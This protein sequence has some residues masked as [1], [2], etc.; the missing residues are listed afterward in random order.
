MFKCFI[1]QAV[2]VPCQSL[3]SHLRLDH[4]FYPSTRFK[5]V[6]AQDRCRRQFSTYSG[7]KKHLISSHENDSCQNGDAASPESF[8]TNFHMLQDTSEF[9]GTSV[10]QN[11][12]SECLDGSGQRNQENTENICAT[13][14]AKL[15][16]SG[17]A[18]SVVSSVVGDLEEL[19][20]G[21]HSQVKQQVLSA[22]PKDNPVRAKLEK[23]LQTFE[24]PF[25]NFSTE[26]KRLKYFNKKWGVVEPV[27]RVLGIRFDTRRNKQTG[28][29]DQGPVNDIFVYIPILET[30]KFMYR[31][32]DICKLLGKTFISRPDRY[33]DFCD[34][35]YSK[36][37]PLFSK[38]PNSLQIQLFYDDFE[39]A[40]QLRSK[41]GVHKIGALYFILRNLP[42]KFNSALM[43]I[44]LVAL[45]H[46]EDLKKYGF[47]PILEPLI[48][49]IKALESCGLDLPFSAE[50]VHGTICQITGDNLGMHAI[51]GFTESFSGCYFCRLCLTEKQ[52]AQNDYNED[53]PKIILRGKELFKMH[54][55]VLQSDP[56]K[57][58]VFGLKKNLILN[59]LQFFHVCHN[60]SLDIM[61]N[62]LEGVAQ[63]E[64]KLLLE[65]LSENV[66]SKPD[67]LSRNYAFDYGYVERKNRPT[68]INL[69]SSGNNIGLNSIQTLCL[70]RNIPLLFGDIVP[71]GNQNCFLLLL[72]LQVINII[73]SP[74]VPLGMTVL[75]KHLIMEH[76]ELLKELYPDRN[77][78]PKHHF[79]IHYPSCIRKIGPLIHMWSMRFEA[80]HRIFKNTL[81]N[82]T[83]SLAK[84]HQMSIACHWE[85]SHSKC[86]EYGPM[87]SIYVD[88]EDY[89][90]VLARALHGES[91]SQDI[92]A[93]NWVTISGTEYRAGL[94]ICSEI[95]HEMP[96][97]CRIEKI[98]VYSVIS[99][100][101][102]KLVVDHFNEHFHAYKVFESNDKDIVKADSLVI[103]KPFD[104]QSAYGGDESQYIVPLFSL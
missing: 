14:I 12:E 51:L 99:F 100:L 36:T 64:L 40:K 20:S 92:H 86:I 54:C 38:H 43:N 50:K 85:T 49:D 73:F 55:N 39:T 62:I 11:P 72:L 79:M 67:L 87:K 66:L 44:H 21:L 34:G 4:S 77:L 95:E 53:D 33:E 58:S 10:M 76:H 13:I 84:K 9:A 23:D 7:F 8:Q 45:F 2:H 35:S 101:V 74:S 71:E 3:I 94:I 65:Y 57:L 69:D 30:I 16:G 60:F 47:N 24:N 82:I 41:R 6:C 32:A 17:I 56:Q 28:T 31:N 19:A 29:Y 25:I 5:L 103:Y 88:N 89:G 15:Q 91:V 59:S 37:H 93:T 1:C 90:D 61:H 97:F 42:P 52:D 75:L 22:V 18:N 98:I 96:V 83:K 26:S 102:N 63:F 46:T 104:L 78:I 68:K 48:N 80:K 27:E 70:V 81:K